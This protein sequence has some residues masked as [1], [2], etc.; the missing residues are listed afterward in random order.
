MASP[1]FEQTAQAPPNKAIHGRKHIAVAVL[2]V[3]IPAT[4]GAIHVRVERHGH[5]GEFS[6]F[7]RIFGSPGG[8]QPHTNFQPYLCVD[9]IISLYGIYP[10]PT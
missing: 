5:R 7:V 4:Q 6:Q 9:F 1:L 10:S 3:P 8:S 2:E